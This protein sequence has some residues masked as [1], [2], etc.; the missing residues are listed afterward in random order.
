VALRRRVDLNLFRILEAIMRHRSVAGA[1]RELAITPSAVSH[2]LARLRREL[3]DPLFIGVEGR[4]VPTPR[5][6][7]LAPIIS[8]GLGRFNDVVRSRQFNPLLVSRTFRIGMSDYA[9]MGLLPVIIER[10]K[11]FAPNV[12]LRILPLH[13]LDLAE[14]LGNG[15]LDL[16]VGFFQGLPKRVRR[17]PVAVE[18]EVLVVRVGHPLTCEPLTMKRVFAF[19]LIAADLSRSEERMCDGFIDEQGLVRRAWLEQLLSSKDRKPGAAHGRI[20]VSVPHFSAAARLASLSDMVTILPRRIALLEAEREPLAVLE[21]PYDLNQMT[22]EAIWHQ[23]ADQDAGLQWLA[24]EI[25]Q[26][27]D[28]F[29]QVSLAN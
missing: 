13:R 3:G 6:L 19:P 8:D 26:V 11:T 17:M 1:S 15:E 4:M 20:A 16:A 5:A 29:G 22:V 9:T 24:T 27:G 12:N 7:E 25:L 28:S 21:L 18:S 10:I 2:A 14:S 23:H